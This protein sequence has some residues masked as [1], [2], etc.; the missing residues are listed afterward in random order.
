MKRLFAILFLSLAG[1]NVSAQAVYYVSSAGDDAAD[2][3]SRTTAFASLTKAVEVAA[4]GDEIRVAA[5]TY[6]LLSTCV[7]DKSLTIKGGYESTGRQN[8]AAK[9]TLDGAGQCKIMQII[10]PL[11][12]NEVHVNLDGF[13]LTNAYGDNIRHGAAVE[14]YKTTGSISNCTFA[15]NKAAA[16]GGALAFIASPAKSEVI[17]CCFHHNEA[18]SGGAIYCGVRTEVALI[19]CTLSANTCSEGDGGA[20]YVDG[21]LRLNNSICLEN[22]KDD[23]PNQIKGTGTVYLNHNILQD[24]IAGIYP[25]TGSETVCRNF[26]GIGAQVGGYDN[27]N[28]LTGS[29]T[30]SE[31]DWTQMFARLQFM[32]PGLVRIMGSEGW[33]Y[34]IGGAYNPQ[35]S[36]DILFKILDFCQANNI[37]VIWGEWSHTGGSAGFD[38]N[39]LHRSIDF[40]DHLVNTKQY[41]CVKYFT[42]V[43]EPNG[44][45]SSVGGNFNL[46]KNLTLA[47]HDIMAEKGLDAKV[48]LLTPDVTLSSGAFT[49]ASPVTHSFVTNAVSA[50]GDVTGAY[51]YHLYPTENQVEN[52]LFYR[53]V[54]AYKNLFPPDKD[55]IIGELGFKYFD[56]TSPK[57]ALNLQLIAD[58][59]YAEDNAC[60]MV[61]E[62]IYGIDISA[63]IVQLMLAGYKASLVWRL[64]DAMYIN[65][66][67]N[68]FKTS[69]WGF[70]NSLGMEKFNNPDD[71]KLRPWFYPISLLAR[72]FPAGS[73]I[74]KVA[75]LQRAGLYAVAARKGNRYTIALVNT[76]SEAYTFEMKM[77]GGR[78]FPDMKRYEYVALDRRNYT[79]PTDENGFPVATAIE[80]ID[81]SADQ[82]H[83][84]T[85]QA[86]S[87][88][89]LTNME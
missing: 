89:L 11:S 80:A 12:E 15:H 23:E 65:V 42:M 24:G 1:G 54:Q 28:Q 38:A 2:G 61:Y 43:N 85:M 75:I 8:Y 87:F 70:W 58:D 4:K 21:T 53:S 26:L 86:S 13:I 67:G 49:G 7:I 44:S 82:S 68:S 83:T 78:L 20:V 51:D 88:T 18:T 35:K 27:L 39:W 81:L 31:A 36:K 46:W 29:P 37:R 60:L 66:T 17:N 9:S 74:L 14:F 59:P 73:A 55:A 5:G 30:L 69:R 32:R 19:N 6:Q 52:D 71:E 63:A 84:L 41:T 33:N 3:I 16:S 22:R 48:Q 40:L 57:G 72:Y 10:R 34:S 77:T 79:G 56:S 50:L 64:D 25:E 45:W 76:A 47:T 62:S